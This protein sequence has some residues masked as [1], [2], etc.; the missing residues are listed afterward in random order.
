MSAPTGRSDDD[1]FWR[2]PEQDGETGFGLQRPPAA[3]MPPAPAYSGPPRVPPP[4]PQW[5]PPVV[6]QPPPP[7]SMPG[8]D[9]EAVKEAEGSA[10]TVTYGI[11]MVAAAILVV[12]MCLLCSRILF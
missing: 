5:Q 2:R 6:A 8:Q 7:R 4:P 12:I 11:G 1:A 9:V 10:R 3:P